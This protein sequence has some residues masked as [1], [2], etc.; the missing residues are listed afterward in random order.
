MRQRDKVAPA[1]DIQKSIAQ[2]LLRDWDPIG[3]KNE[4]QAQD[5]YD[6]YIAGIYRLLAAGATP[7]VVAEHLCRVEA[8]SIGYTQA[9]PSDL[10]PVPE[11][12][13]RLDVMLE[14][15]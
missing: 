10:L 11:K 3:V 15:E 13:C 5:E 7:Q 12:L 4:P 9:S 8:E 14:H 6:S 1:R 2:V